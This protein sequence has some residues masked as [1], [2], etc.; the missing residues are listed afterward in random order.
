MTETMVELAAVDS[1]LLRAQARAG[2]DVRDGG[3]YGGLRT[4]Y[5]GTGDACACASTTCPQGRRTTRRREA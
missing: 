4:A 1:R 2:A 5:A 3:R